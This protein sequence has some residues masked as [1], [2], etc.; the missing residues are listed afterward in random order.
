MI[1][2]RHSKRFVERW[3]K[4]SEAFS[5][6]HLASQSSSKHLGVQSMDD[7]S[8]A[9]H[10]PYRSRPASPSLEPHHELYD[11]GYGNQYTAHVS[12][13]REPPLYSPPPPQQTHRADRSAMAE[14]QPRPLAAA[15]SHPDPIKQS[16]SSST[17]GPSAPPTS[18][19]APKDQIPGHPS[20]RR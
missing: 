17:G 1:Y 19:S 8:H 10:L 18:S 4:R 14:Q 6:P 9:L 13:Q 7:H 16:P 5:T 12:E 11:A 2:S 20:F 15:T 3:R